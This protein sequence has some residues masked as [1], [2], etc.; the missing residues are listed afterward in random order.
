MLLSDKMMLRLK[1]QLKRVPKAPSGTRSAALVIPLVILAGAALVA[2]CFAK[3]AAA[4]PVQVANPAN[5]AEAFLQAREAIRVGDAGRLARLAPLVQGYALEPYLD[6]WR[7]QYR[8]EDRAPEEIRG[9]LDR[10]E[11]SYLAEQL[12]AGWLRVLARRGRWDLFREQRPKLVN[13]EPD[14]ACYGLLARSEAGDATALDE[15]K[16]HWMSSRDLPEG[17]AALAQ[18][19]LS[20]GTYGSEQVW[21]RFRILAD[22]GRPQQ[23]KRVLEWLPR[24]EQPGGRNIDVAYDSPAKYLHQ[25]LKGLQSRAARETAI[26]AFSRLGRNDPQYGAARFAEALRSG[27]VRESLSAEERSHVWGQIA[28]AAARRHMPEA[29]DWFVLADDT[30]LSDEQLAWRARI[31]LRSGA[32]NQ[33]Q[34]AIARMSAQAKADPAWVYWRARARTALGAPA[35]AQ[36]LFARIAGEHHYYGRLAAEELGLAMQLPPKAQQPTPEELLQV[37]STP[38]L[39]RALAL[40][41]LG[42]RFE[43]VREWNWALRGMGDRQLLAAAQIAHDSEI[44]DRAIATADRT[45]ALHDFSLRYPAPHRAIFAE[46]AHARALEEPLVL[47]L[48]RQESRFISNAR[49]TAGASGLMQLMPATARWVAGKLGLK[50]FSPAQTAS[51]DMNATLGTYYL[52]RVL[53]DMDGQ[54]V[55]AAAAY[56]A[57]PGR[58]RAWL[59]AAPMEGAIYVESIPFSETRDYVK[60]VLTNALYYAAVLGGRQ[61]A[62]KERLGRV[63]PRASLAAVAAATDTP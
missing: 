35:E 7:V 32:W 34:G 11:G 60:K 43:G 42:M 38:G 50:N 56:N 33:V 40:F 19:L 30:A 61:P 14:I 8:L 24:A 63:S 58:A 37:S 59:A 17:C 41:A 45:V 49:S 51:I 22:A 44:W 54:A 31:A 57:G 48:V 53:D 25:P 47:G 29:V 21:Q 62:L 13:E 46:Q 27:A 23:A 18:Q 16:A 55:L 6:Y 36:P 2:P 15:V 4:R 28:T 5:P 52:R 26:L 3:P 12:R 1:S 10:N 9:F 20:S 39:Q